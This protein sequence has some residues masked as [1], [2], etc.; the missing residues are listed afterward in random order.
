LKPV[1]IA[2]LVAAGTSCAHSTSAAAQSDG[3][4]PLAG[5]WH[6]VSETREDIVVRIQLIQP[7]GVYG[8][9]IDLPDR[10]DYDL[11]LRID[12]LADTLRIQARRTGIVLD[13]VRRDSV[14]LSGQWLENGTAHPLTLHRYSTDS[15]RRRPQ[16]P[17]PPFPYSSHELLIRSAGD[18][19]IAG[20]LLVPHGEGQHPA[21]ILLPGS[22][23][24]DRDGF[25][26]G[27][28]PLLVLADYLARNGV[29]TFRADIRGV[30]ASEGREELATP[31]DL[32][33]DAAAALAA[34]RERHD[35]DGNRI[36]LI[37]HSEGG[38]VAPLVA[39][40]NDVAFMV[41][42]AAPATSA[43]EAARLQA[44]AAAKAQGAPAEA[45]DIL[46]RIVDEIASI[47]AAEDSASAADSIRNL[48]IARGLVAAGDDAAEV[49][50][51]WLNPRMR[52]LL[53][54]DPAATMSTAKAPVL[55]LFGDLDVQVP[56][57]D[58][59]AGMRDALRSSE[60]KS[61]SVSVLPGINHMMQTAQ[62]GAELEYGRIEETIAPTVLRSILEWLSTQIRTPQ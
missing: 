55:A 15:H 19:R 62:T 3:S 46:G 33:A 26:V 40:G 60:N 52:W 30:A 2:L 17:Q 59:A 58:N 20:T 16:D 38:L 54:H 49:I 43:A 8:G 21:A 34:L 36:G 28:K 27:H 25:M 5:T 51:V 37:G 47:A 4:L 24:L 39:Q 35:I 10:G 18:I 29:A 9:T 57:A 31:A 41:L 53:R 7:A 13:L 1:W 61:W 23:S 50:G 22:G 11:G 45:L 32:A 6:G 44:V 14:T 56:A 42:L 48:L 12:T